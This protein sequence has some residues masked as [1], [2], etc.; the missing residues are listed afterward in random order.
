MT[1]AALASVALLGG[2]SDQKTGTPTPTSAPSSTGLPTDGAPAVTD[3]IANT[4][5]AEADPCSTISNP[6]IESIGGKVKRSELEQ[7]TMGN[8]CAWVFQES[9][10]TVSAGLVTGNKDGLS[11]LYAQHATGGLTTFKPVDPVNGYPAVI[12]ANGGEGKGNC[13]LAIGVRN[14]LVYNVIPRLSSGHPSFS[15]PCGMAVKVAE[16]AIK[17][18]KGA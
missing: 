8:A 18:L 9:P 4:A 10:N 16:A 12:Y 15:D 17:N 1:I 2:C 6:E 11:A 7:L 13:T 14:D 3:P 5:A